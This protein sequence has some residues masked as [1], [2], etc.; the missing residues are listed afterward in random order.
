MLYLKQLKLTFVILLLAFFLNGLSGLPGGDYIVDNTSDSQSCE[1]GTSFYSTIQDA[2][3]AST[4]NS[5]IY[6]CDGTYNEF[7]TVNKNGLYIKKSV[8]ASGEVIITNSNNIF[9]LG[10]IN[11]ILLESLT[12]NSTNK[13]GI[14]ANDVGGVAIQNCTI[15]ADD[16]GIDIN[17]DIDG[18]IIIDTNITS[19]DSAITIAGKIKEEFSVLNSILIAQTYGTKVLGRVTGNLKISST[20][21]TTTNKDGIYFYKRVND[22]INIINTS[23]TAGD[24]G[25]EFRDIIRGKVD[26][27]NIEIDAYDNGIYFH[28]EIRGGINITSA[29]ITTE[30]DVGIKF[31]EDVDNYCNLDRLTINSYDRGLYFNTAFIEPII[32]NSNIISSHSDAI[33]TK[34]DSTTK[35]TLKDSCIKTESLMAYGLN[36]SINGSNSEVTNNC[37][38]APTIFKLAKARKNN[39]NFSGNYWDGNIGFFDMNKIF[40]SN[41]ALTCPN[42]CWG[43]G[44]INSG[45]DAWDIFRDINDRNIST[46]KSAETFSIIITSLNETDD[47]YQK[48]SGTVCSCVDNNSSTCFKNLF[49][50]SN[51][52][53]QTNEGNPT[54]TINKAFKSTNIDIHWQKD[55]DVLCADLVED[56]NTH[57]TDNFAIIPDKFIVDVNDST[58]R[59]GESYRLDIKAT[60]S[61]N[62]I[63]INYKQTFIIN[64]NDKNLSLFFNSKQN[65]M[66]FK[67]T[68]SFEINGSGSKS[69][70]NISDVGEYLLKIVDTAY[71]IVDLDDSTLE[72]RR[73]DGNVTISVIPHHFD[74]NITKHETPTAQNWAYMAQDFS[75][76][77]YTLEGNLTARNKQGSITIYFD[78][79]EYAININSTIIFDTNL[80]AN[81]I[82]E[83]Y[84]QFDNNFDLNNSDFNTS[85][86]SFNN[87]VSLISLIYK[88]DKNCIKPFR[89]VRTNI[90]NF[91]LPNY[92]VDEKHLTAIDDNI[93]W[94][95]S[96]LKTYDVGTNKNITPNHFFVLLYKEDTKNFQEITLNWFQNEDDN[97][98]ITTGFN[99]T[100]SSN[101]IIDNTTNHIIDFIDYDKGRVD[102]NITK[103]G[104]KKAIIHIDIPK[105]LWY[106]YGIDSEYN[107]S[108]GSNC[109]GHPCSIY[110]YET[111]PPSGNT[112]SSGTY[113]GGDAPI[114]EKGKQIRFGVKIFR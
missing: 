85:K 50:D 20:S 5:T 48:F 34:T 68:Y 108:A 114:K 25:I 81:E 44:N 83:F 24:D 86:E 91:D 103:D 16:D 84:N 96:K 67:T 73:I 33:Y 111:T 95:Y 82:T 74:F 22:D 45:F 58:L 107:S 94:Y 10:D 113:Q 87:G 28:D 17:G 102:Y 59:A 70:F 101:T 38:Y 98:S 52:S 90:K 42:S 71:A 36:L 61:L 46:K 9:T 8:D 100:P 13:D 47:D 15:I 43:S 65:G 26:I 35:F 99:L 77:N 23:I 14:K 62:N 30:S 110:T 60:D 79:N 97:S 31:L 18:L 51:T 4:N 32:T 69:D 12:L 29:V 104:D 6:I 1:G 72:D 37:F 88:I 21:I 76:M 39:N 7:I 64:E 106:S 92:T 66:E 54:F 41:P 57:S 49:S 55:V 2:V 19:S 105:Y 40:D 89:P 109:S 27:S 63:I 112:I 3:D 53:A 93:T 56:N 80:T 78:K 75:D 11:D